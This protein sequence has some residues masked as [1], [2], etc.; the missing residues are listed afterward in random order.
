[1][2]NLIYDRTQADVDNKTSKGVYNASDLNRVEAAMAALATRL[3][4]LGYNIQVTQNNWQTGAIP[5][6]SDM[7]TYI[8][9]IAEIRAA[10]TVADST[11]ELPES[12][13]YLNWQ[14]ANAIEKML[15]DVE[16][17]LDETED[18][19][20]FAWALGLAHTGLY[21]GW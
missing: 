20:D 2:L 8:T 1:M 10:L 3:N 21:T 14:G 9:A 13:A 18:S 19:V 7:D 6:K 16:I 17:L 11:P 15:H 12:A 4:A 5:H